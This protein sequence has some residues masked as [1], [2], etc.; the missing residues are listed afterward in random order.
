MDGENEQNRCLTANV[1]AAINKRRRRPCQKT[2]TTDNNDVQTDLDVDQSETSTDFS[3]QL[4]TITDNDYITDSEFATMFDYLKNNNLTGN[5]Q[6]DRFLV[7]LSED[8]MISPE[9]NLLYRISVPRNKK[10]SEAGIV[11]VRLCI[12]VKYR[13]HCLEI[14][15]DKMGHF[16]RD[17][18]FAIM[19]PRLY[20]R[21]LY[22][23]IETYI[24]TCQRCLEVKRNFNPTT[25]PLH[26][27]KPANFVSEQWHFDH[28]ILPRVTEEGYTAGIVFID[29]FSKYPFIRLVRNESAL[30]SARAFIETVVATFGLSPNTIIYS[31]KG[32]GYI[33]KFFKAV[34]SIL[35]V[36]MITS[37]S[38]VSR[39]NGEAESLIQRVK[40]TLKF[41]AKSDTQLQ[42]AIP[43]VELS[44]RSAIST[45]TGL[46]PFQIVHGYEM[47]I[48]VLANQEVQIPFKGP[49]QEY[50]KVI[51]ERLAAL[52]EV[53]RQ[54]ILDTKAK[55]EATYNSRY[56]VSPP[57]WKI[58]DAVLLMN[59][60]IHDQNKVLTKNRYD[61]G[62]IITQIVQSPGFGPSYQL[63]RRDG[64]VLKNLVSHDR[65]KI[66]TSVKR[67]DFSAKNPPLTT[68]GDVV[69]KTV[70]KNAT[71]SDKQSV[72]NQPNDTSDNNSDDVCPAL[73]ILRDK[74]QGKKWLYYVEFED[75]TRAWADFVTPALLNAWLVVKAKR[76]TNRQKRRG[77]M[78]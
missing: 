60:R 57:M 45:A 1:I 19:K 53:T 47:P 24:R 78:N 29:S 55:D 73:R 27:L 71:N 50:L 2:A 3:V 39:T 5:E 70:E 17:K 69:Q 59:K 35:N 77:R 31:D 36:K 11:D 21:R 16:G 20:W 32:A 40:N 18:T 30:E 64:R 14:F 65:L 72:D 74:K 75:R 9:D 12:P 15:H 63:T 42:A 22:S 13:Q 33:S 56:N 62:Y 68:D 6:E 43:M 66:D 61:N 51:V 76:K 4:P 44:L 58:G 8:F 38:G 7:L 48:P 10:L 34:T 46:S 23:D 28:F 49:Q 37:A 41:Y 54:K 25:V 26:P 67:I 52:R